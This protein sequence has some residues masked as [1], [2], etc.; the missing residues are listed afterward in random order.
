MR[1]KK[2]T[3]L[4]LAS[5]LSL[6]LVF[7]GCGKKVTAQ[8]CAQVL[9]DINVKF[10]TSN[11]SKLNAKEEDVQALLEKS[12]KEEKVNLKNTYTAAGLTVTDEQIDQIYTGVVNAV[13][14]TNVKVEEVSNDGQ[15]ADIKYITT[16]VDEGKLDKKASEEAFAMVQALNLTSQKEA[17]EK[18][19]EVYMANLLNELKN[20]SISGETKEKVYKF[21]KKDK[22]W[23]PEDQ[24]KFAEDITKL[25]TNQI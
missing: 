17:L 11:V 5:L 21:V 4:L 6:S 24:E 10:D 14:K 8:E 2:F 9:W 20:V 25:V 13:G 1:N 23:L 15:T 16:Y 19:S 18:L 22:I 12:K 3:A 7:L